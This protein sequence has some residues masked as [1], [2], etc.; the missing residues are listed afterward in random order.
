M[1][2]KSSENIRENTFHLKRIFNTLKEY[3]PVFKMGSSSSR[4]PVKYQK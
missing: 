2:L 3:R 1:S 4:F